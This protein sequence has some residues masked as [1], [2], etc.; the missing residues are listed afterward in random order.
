VS[1]VPTTNL[2]RPAAR[3]S[4]WMIGQL[5]I[6]MLDDEFFVRF[7]SIFQ[8]VGSTLLDGVDN[9]ANI[10][11][12]TVTPE[13][14]LPWLGSWLGLDWLQSSFSEEAKRRIVLNYGDLLAWRGTCE[15]L[16]RFLEVLTAGTVE[17]TET[18][19][20]FASGEAP[21][22]PPTVGIRT[23][24]SAGIPDRDLV[25]IIREE[26]PATVTFELWVGPRR[27]WPEV[28]Q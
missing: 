11:D 8:G 10:M 9:I 14:F 15:G 24:S 26:L 18:G 19:G 28:D 6:G 27:L 21:S 23:S 13:A 12:A 2:A 17:V 7:V 25:T 20:V 3:R 16:T 22:D 5:P 4:D 1:A